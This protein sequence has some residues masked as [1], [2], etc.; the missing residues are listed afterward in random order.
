MN[1]TS[2][3]ENLGLTVKLVE[4]EINHVASDYLNKHYFELLKYIKTKFKI[5]TKAEDLLSDVMSSLLMAEE[6]GEGYNAF[7]DGSREDEGIILV[8]QFVIGRIKGYAKNAKYNDEIIEQ[9]RAKTRVKQVVKSEKLDS[10]GKVM[11]DK[12]GNIKYERNV[13]KVEKEEVVTVYAASFNEGNDIT[14]NNDSFQI[15]YAMA[16]VND[17][18]NEVDCSE[19]VKDCIDL[20]IDICS[21]HN[22]NIL[23]IFKHI[24]ELAAL[25]KSTRNYCV[26]EELN[27]LVNYHED[28]ADA[29]QTV[30]EFSTYNRD[31]L[32]TLLAAY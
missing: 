14:E 10:K 29:I 26:F 15:G 5:K 9:H 25:A 19:S 31:K 3:I 27:K 2:L 8:E 11:K 13:V 6:E 20:C 16:S 32:Q 18:T 4:P 23:N 12:L 7:Y 30:F 24:D 1:K 22:F 17:T 21:V 28:L